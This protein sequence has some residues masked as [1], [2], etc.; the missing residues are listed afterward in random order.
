MRPCRVHTSVAGLMPPAA[1]SCDRLGGPAGGV[2]GVRRRSKFFHA[3]VKLGVADGPLSDSRPEKMAQ[4]ST[5][6]VT[7]GTGPMERWP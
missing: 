3:V 1:D 6:S 2:V 4:R 5:E 7:R